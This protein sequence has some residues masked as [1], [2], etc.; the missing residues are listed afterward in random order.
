[1]LVHC[2]AGKDRTGVAIAILLALLG[3]TREAILADY[4]K[5]VVLG[6]NLAVVGSVNQT[7]LKNFGFA[8]S[9][10]VMAM[11]LGTD[12]DFV[13][14]ALRTVESRWGSVAAYFEAS[15]VERHRQDQ[16]RATLL[17]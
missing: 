17:A 15:G 14:A 7:F 9:E 16:L 4:A 3:V 12:N 13:L 2:T 8:P 1:M 5:S 10:A 6:G 11:L